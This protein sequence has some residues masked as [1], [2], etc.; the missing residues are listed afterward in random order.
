VPECEKHRRVE[1]ANRH[2]NN[3]RWNPYS[4]RVFIIHY[5]TNDIPCHEKLGKDVG[6]DEVDEGE[7]CSRCDGV[8]WRI[9]VS[10]RAV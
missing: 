3:A 5:L 9:D 1:C 2:V 4:G 10:G 8:W 6:N 7:H